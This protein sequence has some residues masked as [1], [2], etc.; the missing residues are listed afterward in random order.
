MIFNG[1]SLLVRNMATDVSMYYAINV[2]TITCAALG[3][4]QGRT[5]PA[6]RLDQGSC[7]WRF[8]DD[9]ISRCC[10]AHSQQFLQWISHFHWRCISSK[11][12]IWGL[13]LLVAGVECCSDNHILLFFCFSK[14]H[15][16][17][18]NQLSCVS[19]ESASLCEWLNQLS[20]LF[21]WLIHSQIVLKDKMN[22]KLE[23]F[24]E[25]FSGKFFGKH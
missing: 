16:S 6:W 3:C 23:K 10:F 15:C 20:V 19:R 11:L 24:F 1:R 5:L 9:E 14:L 8:D 25:K 17:T 4:I 18:H 21:R 22:I 13:R 2:T 12:S 7:W